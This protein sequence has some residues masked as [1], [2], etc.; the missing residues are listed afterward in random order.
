MERYVSVVAEDVRDLRSYF[1]ENQTLQRER[2]SRGQMQFDEIQEWHR[3]S[4]DELRVLKSRQM[5]ESA[6]RKCGEY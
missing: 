5:S 1:E 3:T 2:E 4:H 6:P